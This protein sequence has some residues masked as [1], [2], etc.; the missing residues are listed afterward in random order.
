M[1]PERDAFDT[2]TP[3][4]D[5]DELSSE[6]LRKRMHQLSRAKR[7]ARAKQGHTRPISPGSDSATMSTIPDPIGDLAA[8]LAPRIAIL[9]AQAITTPT[10][11]PP[12]EKSPARR[13]PN[14][15]SR[16]RQQD[17]IAT[18][19]A[20]GTPLTRPE[21]EGKMKL[22]TEGKLGHHLAWMVKA[23]ILTNIKNRGY[24]PADLSL[25]VGM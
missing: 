11:A 9:L 21:I 2:P 14:Q 18:I 3:E 12:K 7:A 22:K 5:F 4:R 25:P 1:P 19:Q 16:D 23:G 20:E 13:D 8:Q 15:P 6:E 17:I 24:W 10:E